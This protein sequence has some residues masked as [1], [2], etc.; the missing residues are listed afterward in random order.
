VNHPVAVMRTAR[1]LYDGGWKPAEIVSLIE[2]EHG[3]RIHK[4]TIRIWASEENRERHSAVD[5]RQKARA[6]ARRSGGRLR[7]NAKTPEF[8]EQR[9]LGLHGIGISAAKIVDL[10]AFDLEVDMTVAQVRRTIE[11]GHLPRPYNKTDQ[12]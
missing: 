4:N 3:V 7:S 8:I 11:I 5:N 9:I 1:R 2:R 10:L 12:S 6:R